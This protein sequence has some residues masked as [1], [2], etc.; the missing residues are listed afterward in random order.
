MPA[1]RQDYHHQFASPRQRAQLQE[2]Y[3]QLVRQDEAPGTE[4]VTPKRPLVEAQPEAV[5]KP[6]GLSPTTHFG[7]SLA[8]PRKHTRSTSAAALMTPPKNTIAAPITPH[9]T[10]VHLS[11]QSPMNAASAAQPSV[12]VATVK[13]ADVPDDKV[14]VVVPNSGSVGVEAMPEKAETKKT[15][16]ENEEITQA[17]LKGDGTKKLEDGETQ[18]VTLKGNRM[19][20]IASSAETIPSSAGPKTSGRG[21][22]QGGRRAAEGKGARE[23]EKNRAVTIGVRASAGRGDSARG[24][25]QVPD[26]IAYKP[27]NG[28]GRGRGAQRASTDM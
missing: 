13:E 16:L 21:R 4:N 3:D 25:G 8:S 23:R 28:R 9:R 20:D 24:R 18:Q 2:S 5:K 1:K 15:Q 6:N 26:R 22:G 7:P 14:V 17:T 11:K 27:G 12:V 10:L 19:N